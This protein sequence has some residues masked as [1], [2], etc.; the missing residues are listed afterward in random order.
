MEQEPK[1]VNRLHQRVQP[2]A[3]EKIEG[4]MV[5][6]TSNDWAPPHVDHYIVP[7]SPHAPP[8]VPAPRYL[9]RVHQPPDYL[10]Y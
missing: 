1:H 7:M 6:P 2:H 9:R 3:T 5:H 10:R 8:P 4:N